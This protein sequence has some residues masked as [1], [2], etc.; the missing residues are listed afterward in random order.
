MIAVDLA[1]RERR[2]IADA[3]FEWQGSA[4]RKPLPIEILGCASWDQFD[5]LCTRLRSAI[6]NSE[7][8]TEKDWATALFLTEIAWAS[9]LVGAGLDFAIVT[10]F[11]D[12]EAVAL[13]RAIQRKISSA[14]RAALLFPAR[15]RP[16]PESLP[17]PPK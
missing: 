8:L 12:D 13:L 4:G 10:S 5:H 11:G 15:G 3:L 7:S 17:T 14:E 6:E 2:F 9:A 1:H 16:Q